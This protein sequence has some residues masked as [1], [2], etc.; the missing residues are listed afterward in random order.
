MLGK[1]KENN[2]YWTYEKVKKEAKKYQRKS[3][4]FSHSRGSY[5]AAYRNGWFEKVSAHMPSSHKPWGYW[6][7]DK[8]RHEAKKYQFLKDF[9]EKAL[10][11]YSAAVENDWFDDVCFHLRRLRQKQALPVGYWT[12]RRIRREA[13]KY[14]SRTAFKKGALSAYNSS[15]SKGLIKKIF[16]DKEIQNPQGHWTFSRVRREAKKYRK[17]SEFLYGTGSAYKAALRNGWLDEVCSHMTQRNSY[18]ELSKFW[19]DER[20]RHEAKQYR[21]RTQFKRVSPKAY[22]VAYKKGL[23][24]RLFPLRTFERY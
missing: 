23:L 9:R 19:S 2:R 10:G 16:P 8:V 17:R 1:S 15:V 22:F 7:K 12:E 24:D 21:T 11:A 20:L 5:N 14:R 4:W 3:D 6:T 13:K 18:E